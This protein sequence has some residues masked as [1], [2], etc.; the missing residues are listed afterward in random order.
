MGGKTAA[1]ERGYCRL[2]SVRALAMPRPFTPSQKRRLSL[3]A[4]WSMRE[5][6]LPRSTLVLRE[7][8]A[9]GWRWPSGWRPGSEGIMRD[10]TRKPT[11]ECGGRQSVVY[12]M[13]RDREQVRDQISEKP[14][15]Q[16]CD[17]TLQRIPWKE[18]SEA[19]F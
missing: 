5:Y 19:R 2:T 12:C 6:S 3:F 1:D 4:D 11:G 17:R 18:S 16:E 14:R 9:D 15:N 7:A 13:R 10:M 8:L